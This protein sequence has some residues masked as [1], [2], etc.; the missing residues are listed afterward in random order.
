MATHV[1]SYCVN[2]H[3]V[4]CA[5]KLCARE[6]KYSIVNV[7]RA[8][9]DCSAHNL[10]PYALLV[11]FSDSFH[12]HFAVLLPMFDVINTP[13][14]ILEVVVHI[15]GNLSQEKHVRDFLTKQ[16]GTVFIFYSL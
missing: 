1:R 8:K 7:Q 4:I 9:S 14:E 6:L 15:L 3:I 10:L 16:K 11:L 13:R 12:F 5:Y 2:T